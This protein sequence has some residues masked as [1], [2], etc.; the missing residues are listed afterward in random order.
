MSKK[1]PNFKL[2]KKAFK[3]LKNAPENCQKTVAKQS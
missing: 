1:T 2:I 3:N